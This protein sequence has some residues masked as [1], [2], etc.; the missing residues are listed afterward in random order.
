MG[1]AYFFGLF[2][3]LTGD[4][5]LYA[6]ISR[7][8][9]ESGDWFNLKINGDPYD[10]KPHLF[11]W[12]AGLGIQLF[13][14]TNFAFKLFPFLYGLIGIYFTY[15]LGEKLFSAKA[16]KLAALITGTSQI[17]FLYFFD[18]HT[19]TV[20]Q[21]GV[22]L[23]L[24][25]LAAY[26]Q[27]NKAVNFV[28]GFFGVG[29]AMLSKGPV[30]AVIPFFAVLLYLLV[31]KDFRQLFN[32]KWILGI[33]IVCAIIS[34]T[35]LYL[36]KNFG[37]DGLKFYFITNNFGRIT[38]EYAGSSSNPLFYI[39]TVLWAFL[40]W[41]IFV[42]ISVFNE[43]K[44]WFNSNKESIWGIYL[45]GGVLALL[46][47]LSIAKGKSPN[48]FLIAI[49]VVSVVVAN[50]VAHIPQLS[51]KT[52]RAVII[53]Q[54]I[55]VTFLGVFMIFIFLVYSENKI[56]LILFLLSAV[57][58][59]LF[60]KYQ[61]D[62]FKRMLFVSVLVSGVLNLFL[63]TMVI[64]KLY[65][66]Q[67][68]RQALEIYESQRKENDVLINLQLEEYELFYYTNSNIQEFTDWEDFYVLFEKAGTWIYT[69]KTGYEGILK[70]NHRLDSVFKIRHRGMNE[71]T[72]RFLNPL[73]RQD[74][75]KENYL[76]KVHSDDF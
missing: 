7:Q 10:Q 74:E 21:T 18:F 27:N 20:L 29:L 50:W 57:I 47:I 2:I 71:I 33:L 22:V 40:P 48:Y 25:Q 5:G 59:V 42:L 53:S 52:Q 28:L 12:L 60:Y 13:E 32:P 39:E 24:W 1:L 3:D 46:L 43:I 62:K 45:L 68:A 11:F 30:G 26:M 37:A 8:M 76:I 23:A 56:F 44:N 4:S 55:Y 66:F 35:L 16:G 54:Y 73:T 70:L 14:N 51:L 75:L 49:P 38:G 67:G 15:R 31:K 72:F 17:F 6:A 58:I 63:N 64:P 34:P 69:N 9:V 61:K 41:T 65:T 19:D 36:Y